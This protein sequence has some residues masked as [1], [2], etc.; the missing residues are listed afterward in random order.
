MNILSI[1]AGAAS[2]YCGSCLRDNALAAELLARGHGVTL[3]PVYTP[4][5]TDEPNVS[6][7]NPVLFG[8]VSVY[9]E[10]HVP[11]FRHTPRLLDRLWDSMAVLRAVSKR[12]LKTNP[13]T[14]GALTVSVLRGEDGYQRKEIDKLIEWVREERAPDLVNLP[15][16]LLIALAAPL[17]RAL[18]RPICCTLQGEDVFLEGLPEPWRSEAIALIRQ[19]AADVD[20]FISVSDYYVEAM[21]SYLRIPGDRIAVVPLG[22]NLRGY[23]DAPREPSTTFTVGYFAR[24]APEKGLAELCQA[25]RLF[26][27][28]ERVRSA[29]LEVAGYLAAEHRDYLARVQH[30]MAAAGLAG[31]FRYHGALDREQKI[32]F[33][34]GLDVLSVPGPFPDPKGLYLLEAMAAGV[35]VVQPRRGAYPEVV[36]RTGGGLI[37]EPSAEG[38]ANGLLRLYADR[39]LAAALGARGAAGVREHYTVQKSADRLLDVYARVAARQPITERLT[40]AH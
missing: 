13:A 9:L 22:I 39:G 24:V 3:L 16:S 36:G 34:R 6:V 14:L 35:P 17:R 10:Q 20:A 40:H 30:D 26:R 33:L 4:T 38:L 5:L 15:N 2:M 37:V 8:G 29:R 27:H 7:G 23:D 12:S 21:A 31:E 1:T 11:L 28:D 18:A 19:K 25:Y 32:R